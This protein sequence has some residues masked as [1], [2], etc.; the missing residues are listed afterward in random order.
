[1]HNKHT[2]LWVINMDYKTLTIRPALLPRVH[3]YCHYHIHFKYG[4]VD[5]IVD[6]DPLGSMP[7]TNLY[8]N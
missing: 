7:V 8:S 6:T 5:D 2:R 4:I 1:M 3:R